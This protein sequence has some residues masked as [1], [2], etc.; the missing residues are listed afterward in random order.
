MRV[1]F[2]TEFLDDGKTI[3]LISIGMVRED[4]AELYLESS[5]FDPARATDWLKQNVLPSLKGGAVALDRKSI[6]WVVREFAGKT[7][8]FWAYYAAYDWVALCQL[9]GPMM[10]IPEGWPKHCLD[11][12]QQLYLKGNPSVQRPE[13]GDHNALLDARW[14]FRVWRDLQQLSAP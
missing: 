2:D 10:S 11:L 14:N 6:G 5:E 4:G 8:E 1:F 13:G 12:Q 7:A 3:D 9:Y